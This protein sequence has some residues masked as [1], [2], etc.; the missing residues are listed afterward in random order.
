MQVA[1]G[2]DF[3]VDQAVTRH[4]VEHVIEERHTGFEVGAPA[5]VEIKLDADLRFL[6]VAGDFGR[7]HGEMCAARDSMASRGMVKV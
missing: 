3:E 4:L 5:A 6:G 1:Y 7:S 2:L